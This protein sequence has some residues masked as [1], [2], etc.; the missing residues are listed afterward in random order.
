MIDLNYFDITQPVHYLNS[1]KFMAQPGWRHTPNR[2]DNTEIMIGLAGTVFLRIAEQPVTLK[3]GQVLCLAPQTQIDGDRPCESTA[4]FLWFHFSGQ[5]PNIVS[6]AA[7]TPR[8]IA[9]PRLF[10][11]KDPTRSLL[12]GQQLLDRG[13]RRNDHPDLRDYQTTLALIELA[14]DYRLQQQQLLAPTLFQ[15][16]E[17]IRVNLKNT[18]TLL[19]I[20]LHFH[21][22]PDY[23]NRIFKQEFG[24][25]I[26]AYLTDARLDLA[27]YLLLTTNQLVE[28]IGRTCCFPDAHYFT[29]VFKQRN[30]V[31][32]SQYR[33]NYAAT[34]YNNSQLDS[35]T[36]FHQIVQDLEANKK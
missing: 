22:N 5:L 28:E 21:L 27:K 13:H 20:A 17:W 16:R 18:L 25:T 31:T 11:L 2:H 26:K 4:Q 33:R 34:F 30:L 12:A 35:G 3:A 1:G 9:L 8:I 29:R 7:T 6:K 36:D 32:P 14:N 24:T 15:I 19:Q 10:Q 23:L